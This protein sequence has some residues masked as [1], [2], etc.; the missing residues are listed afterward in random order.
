MS[1]DCFKMSVVRL[2]YST[3]TGEQKEPTIGVTFREGSVRGDFLF[4]MKL[5]PEISCLLTVRI[6]CR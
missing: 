3:M 2:N 1:V 6:C 5:S 4:R